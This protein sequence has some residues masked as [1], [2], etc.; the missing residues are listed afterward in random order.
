M[1]IIDA[2][3]H[4]SHRDKYFDAIA[5]TAGHE[6]TPEHLAA[7]YKKYDVESGVVMGN[8]PLQ[9]VDVTYPHFL[10][11]LVGLDEVFYEERNQ[12]ERLRFI[13]RHLKR[14]NCRG[15][16][17]Y[18][19]Y[20]YFYIYDERLAPIYELAVK[21]NKPVAVHTGL[22]A[23]SNSLLKYCHPLVMD[24]AVVNFPAVRFVMC[25]FGEPWFDD[26]AAVMEKNPQITADLSGMLEGKISDMPAFLRRTNGFAAKLKDTLLYLDAFDRFMFGTDWPL[27][28]FGDY[29]EFTKAVIPR[30]KWEQVFYLNAKRIYGI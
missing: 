9:E 24:E 22:T 1:K 28:N 15:I 21:Y 16:K 18:P 26:A 11:Y 10:H 4:F 29:V 25:H 30:E 5:A 17:L 14:K 27:A 12:D 20:R 7:V 3:L 6:N 23:G 2:H 19:G 13:E 8:E